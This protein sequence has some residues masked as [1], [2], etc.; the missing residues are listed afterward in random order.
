MNKV[1][2][3]RQDWD[4][5][6][7]MNAF[8]T[9]GRDV[10]LPRERVYEYFTDKYNEDACEEAFVLTNAPD[11]V[12]TEHQRLIRADYRGPSVSV[13]DMIEV[14]S[15]EGVTDKYICDSV[16]WVHVARPVKK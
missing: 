15:D 4:A 7:R 10:N 1:I 5:V 8:S 14:I 2:I 13:G 11:E 9:R 3:H 6:A 16:G 12:L